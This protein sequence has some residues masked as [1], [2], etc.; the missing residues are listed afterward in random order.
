MRKV[1]YLSVIMFIFSFLLLRPYHLERN[2][3]KYGGDDDS[4]MAHATSLAFFQFPSYAKENFSS[5]AETPMHSVGP[6][7]MASPF[8]FCFSILDRIEKNPLVEQ[9]KGKDISKSWTLFGFVVSTYFY[10]WLACFLLFMGLKYFVKDTA[11]FYSVLLMILVQGVCLY[12]YRRPVFSHIYELFLQSFFVYILLK[13]EKT[14]FLE[15]RKIPAVIGIGIL[16]SLVFLVRYNNIALTFAWPAVLFLFNGGKIS[17][18]K[19][20]IE[21]MILSYLV[22]FAMIFVFKILPSYYGVPG[23]YSHDINTIMSLHNPGYYI[24]GILRVLFFIDWGLVF[25]APFA[26]LALICAVFMKRSPLKRKIIILLIPLLVN[27][28]VIL[29]W[30]TQGGWYGYRYIIFVLFPLLVFPMAIFWEKMTAKFS[31]RFYFPVLLL[32]FLPLFSMLLF[33]GNADTLTLTTVQSW[34]GAGGWTNNYYQYEV[35][36]VILTKPV[37]FFIYLFKGGA[38]Y[39]LYLLSMVL[40]FS[41][42][43]PAELIEKYNGFQAITLARLLI[44]YLFPFAMYFLVKGLFGKKEWENETDNT[45]TLL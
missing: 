27:L 4:Y 43:L 45:D 36:K 42:R 40:G 3:L 29:Q 10:F 26:I 17:I 41:K 38:A 39:F 8:V 11:A 34:S 5:G 9:R 12:V 25:T 6:G 19:K 1:F 14:G 16:S 13:N 24:R 2:G 21:S 33:E 15:S 18:N 23:A 28:F 35:W 22:A 32:S 31:W 30:G 7:I 20:N 37:H 44:L